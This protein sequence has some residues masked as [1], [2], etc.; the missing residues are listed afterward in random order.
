VGSDLIGHQDV[1]STLKYNRYRLSKSA[2]QEIYLA[3][4]KLTN[5]V[6]N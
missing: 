1:R 2:I 6:K 3:A 4:E 5:F